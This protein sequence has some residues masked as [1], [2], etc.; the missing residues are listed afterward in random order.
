INPAIG[1]GFADGLRSILRQD[2]N[3]IM[4]G[5][6]RDGETAELAIHAALTGHLVFSTLHTNSAISAIPRLIDMGMEPFLLSSSI[7]AVAAQRLVRKLCDNCKKEFKLPKPVF[8][9]IYDS[10]KNITPEEASDYGVKSLKAEDMKFYHAE[11]C[12]ECGRTGYKGR[13]AIY[14]CVDINNEVREVIT[15][16]DDVLLN[17]VA[18]KQGM[19][20]MRQDGFLKALLGLTS[21]SEVERMTEGSLTVG[22]FEDD[23][24]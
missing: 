13:L 7:N 2:P 6:I 1:Y 20:N 9:K 11:G 21:I 18:Q 15:E 14:E 24:G 23:L 19:L 5:E 3:V 10:L 8:D 16:K 4:I 22:E 12:D 17:R